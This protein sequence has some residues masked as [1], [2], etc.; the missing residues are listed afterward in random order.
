LQFDTDG[1]K[2]KFDDVK[3]SEMLKSITAQ[4]VQNKFGFILSLITALALFFP[5][6]GIPSNRSKKSIKLSRR[7]NIKNIS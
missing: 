4:G 6:I 7:E 5:I 3:N 2:S 1:L